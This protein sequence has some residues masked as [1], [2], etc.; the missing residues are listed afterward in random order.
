MNRRHFIATAIASLFAG[1]KINIA[2][3]E[4]AQVQPKEVDDLK[5]RLIKVRCGDLKRGPETRLPRP[6][7]RELVDHIREH[8]LICPMTVN[9]NLSII[10]GTYRMLACQEIDENMMVPVFQVNLTDEE[11][12]EYQ[13]MANTVRSFTFHPVTIR[14]HKP[15]EIVNGRIDAIKLR[16]ALARGDCSV[17]DGYHRVAA[18]SGSIAIEVV[19]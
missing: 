7:P 2:A 17:V 15:I 12:L 14:E 18:A 3:C 19:Q 10:D 1:G 8:G 9:A 4:Q 11:V 16:E 6:V 13:M 5:P